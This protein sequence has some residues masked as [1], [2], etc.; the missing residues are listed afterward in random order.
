MSHPPPSNFGTRRVPR[1]N[2]LSGGGGV[3]ISIHPSASILLIK[4]IN[5]PGLFKLLNGIT[6]GL[7]KKDK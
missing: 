6:D 5:I 4:L 1:D 7:L 2:L 3:G